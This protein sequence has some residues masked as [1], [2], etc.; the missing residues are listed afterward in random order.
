MHNS[1]LSYACFCFMA[2]WRT[3]H[4]CAQR[5][6]AYLHSACMLIGTQRLLSNMHISILLYDFSVLSHACFFSWHAG[7]KRTRSCISP[8]HAVGTQCPLANIH[9]SILLYVFFCFVTYMFMFRGG[10]AMQRPLAPNVNWVH[11]PLLFFFLQKMGCYLS[12]YDVSA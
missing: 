10:A 11:F 6:P 2:H 8:T 12:I 9:V 3:T 7:T 4:V 5:V 1:V